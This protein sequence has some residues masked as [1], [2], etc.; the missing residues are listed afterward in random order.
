MHG[1]LPKRGVEAGGGSAAFGAAVAPP[2]PKTKEAD[3]AA[4]GVPLPPKTKGADDAAEG[5]AEAEAPNERPAGVGAPKEGAAAAG[6][7]NEKPVVVE[8]EASA[9]SPAV[10]VAGTAG[11]DSNAVLA[12]LAPKVKAGF[13][14]DGF[15]LPKSMGAAGA[16]DLSGSSDTCLP[17]MATGSCCARGVLLNVRAPNPVDGASAAVSCADSGTFPNARE[18][19]PAAPPKS[20][21]AAGAADLSGSCCKRGVLL[22]V[23][24]PKP[25]DGASAAVSGADSGAFPNVPKPA[26]TGAWLGGASKA[27]WPARLQAWLGVSALGLLAALGAPNDG[28]TPKSG[29]ALVLGVICAGPEHELKESSVAPAHRGA[30]D[31]GAG[32]GLGSALG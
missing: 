3:S 6:I 9:V 24:A 32:V 7:P 13:S 21:G 4:L 22:N 26:A 2:P 16:A 30:F 8:L 29:I 25:V 12:E 20:M 31:S 27:P 18:P 23:R 11:D 28:R 15:A 5:G 17:A 14:A 10:G 1:A 19:M